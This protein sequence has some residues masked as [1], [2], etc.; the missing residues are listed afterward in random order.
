MTGARVFEKHFTDDNNRQG[1]D[2]KFAMNPK[3]WRE[4]VERA[5]EVYL[6]LGDGKKVI[7]ENEQ[8]TAVLQRR[9]LRTVC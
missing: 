8:E 7:E 2:H 4:M 9:P 3:A 6:A 5:N 1:P